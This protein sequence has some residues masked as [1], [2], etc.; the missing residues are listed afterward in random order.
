MTMTY[1]CPVLNVSLAVFDQF[2][3][4]HMDGRKLPVM[5]S[6]LQATENV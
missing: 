2:D 1:D 5:K 6:S 3:V 4:L